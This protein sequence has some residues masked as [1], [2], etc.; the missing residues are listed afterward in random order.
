MLGV[1][2]WKLLMGGMSV[3]WGELAEKWLQ[4]LRLCPGEISG[5]G[6]EV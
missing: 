1:S 6:G 3:I 4:G 5:G 2:F